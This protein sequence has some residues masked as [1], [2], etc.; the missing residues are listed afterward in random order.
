M[1]SLTLL[2]LLSN[3]TGFIVLFYWLNVFDSTLKNN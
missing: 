1:N 3:G 2:L